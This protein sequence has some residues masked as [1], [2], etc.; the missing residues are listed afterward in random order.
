MYLKDYFSNLKKKYYNYSFSGIAS[1]SSK[2]KKNFI[3]F[4]IKGNKYDGHDFISE[5]IKN[6]AK[7]I[8][9][10]KRFT[11][12]ENKIL[13]INSK[14]IR[15]LL[16]EVSF[17]IN[18]KIPK[19]LI[20]VTGTNGKSSISDF[21][22]QILKLNKIKVASIGTLG[23]KKNNSI[24]ILA[25]TTMDPI[26]LSIELK[27]LKNQKIENVIMEAS[28]HGLKQHR[29]DG[30]V[31]DIG[32]FSNLS[33]DHLDYHKNLRD[34]FESKLYLFKNLIKKNGNIITD[35]SIKQFF[36][37]KNISKNKNLQ[38][39]Y[40]SLK[41]ENS[42]IF[43]S[44]HKFKN[45]SQLIELNYRNNRF[46]FLLNLIGKVQ[47]KN[48]L[49]AVIAAEKSGLN[50]KNIFNCLSKIKPIN[51][52]LEK[53]GK[54]NNNSKV[55]L[56]YAHT[57]DAL[58]IVLENLND[59]FLKK[60][61]SIVFGCGGDR[62]KSKRKIMG[63]IA[64]LYCDRIYLTDDNP[65]NENPKSIRKEI[66]KGLNSKKI[67]EIADR[68]KAINQAILDLKSGEILLVAGKGHEKTQ[69]YKKQIR[70]FSDKEI[71]LKSINKKNH[72]ISKNIKLNIIKDL[73][74]S[75]LNFKNLNMKKIIINS[76][77]VNKNDI[78][79]TIK[80]KKNDAHNYLKEVFERKASLAIVNKLNKYH[81]PTKQIKVSNT[82]EF[83]TSCASR[84]RDNIDTKI[85]AITGSCG[86]TSLKD[87][88]SLTLRKSFKTSFSKKSFNNKYG[89]PL[90]LL[91]INSNDIFGV[92]EVGM[93]KKGEIDF[94]SKMIMPDIGII[95]N[96]S[97]AHI[98]NFKNIS[99]IASA[100]G[101]II[102]NIKKNGSVILNADDDFFT[103]H[104]RIAEKR[105]LK[106]FTFSKNKKNTTV[107]LKKIIKQ[108]NKY[109][110]ILRV[111]NSEKYF[112]IRKNFQ[113]F[114]YNL[115][116]TLTVMQIYININKLSKNEF[117]NIETTKGRGDI[118]KLNLNGKS[119]FLVDESYNSNPLSLS[120]ALENFDK[121]LVN[122]NKKHIILGDMLELGKHSKKLHK[123]MGQ[124]INKISLNKVHVIGKEIKETFKKI[125]LKKRGSI[126]KN[127]SELNKLILEELRDGDYLM[128]KGSNS[129]GLFNF[130]TKLKKVGI[131]AL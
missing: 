103:F 23:I 111:N 31:F 67:F 39:N 102:N 100:K 41:K 91:N 33:H 69:I 64:N 32:V 80:G 77:E 48:L 74:N 57:P 93:D 104:K 125:K 24:K 130:V 2:I 90:S 115:M 35:Q 79:F 126:L 4:A 82:L 65:R 14:N 88:L 92:L 29:L 89:V 129:S 36:K 52:R 8:I 61:I 76:K 123:D 17:K 27:K 15:K 49:M 105:K 10:E 59:Q 54:I 97:F 107:N 71:I 68:K 117:L 120:S 118:I 122:K 34:Y 114:I 109:K 18:P 16:A 95:T 38:L 9:H 94:L 83:L 46:K 42:Q 86:K 73:S 72:E 58:K 53:I 127:D 124:K 12:I 13:F 113:N 7:I 119:I 128:I 21:Y 106:I 5:A 110:I 19:N 108:K 50:I 40:L 99:E 87:L 84:F 51:G 78:F 62:D 37:I 11:G 3:F 28:S 70:Y 25:N 22:Y 60:K 56:D 30:L 47:L 6:G 101:E 26:N 81:S 75:N 20:A 63:K 66:K 85:I 45:E 44:S 98:K 112:F 43:I 96:V 131:N 121:I 1:Q 116:A 55:I